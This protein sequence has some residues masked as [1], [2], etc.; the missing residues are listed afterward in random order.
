MKVKLKMEIPAYMSTY[1]R[2][3][4]AALAQLGPPAALTEPGPDG[5]DLLFADLAGGRKDGY[6]FEY[7]ASDNDGDGTLDAYQVSASPI[8]YRK[9]GTRSFFTDK[10]GVIRST[11]EDRS[12]T[13]ADPPVSPQPPELPG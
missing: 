2:G 10:S 4:P 1:S 7:V 12:A 9:T 3:V 11:K 6:V 13:A 8:E 5:A